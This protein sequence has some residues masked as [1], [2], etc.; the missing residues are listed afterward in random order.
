M[1]TLGA[2]SLAATCASSGSLFV[3]PIFLVVKKTLHA[4]NSSPYM[5]S[6]G[7]YVLLRITRMAPILTT[8]K[9][10]AAYCSQLPA[11]MATRSPCRIPSA[12]R[13]RAIRLD[14]RR[15]SSYDQRA[16]VHGM[17][18]QSAS[19]LCWHCSSR[20][21]PRVKSLRGGST[22]PC[23]IDGVSRWIMGCSTAEGKVCVAIAG[24][25]VKASSSLRSISVRF[26]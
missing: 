3:L 12:S 25:G 26:R 9:K 17:L 8:A 10:T 11:M 13:A 1:T 4:V 18:M 6:E 14:C 20:S 2:L 24:N 7:V 22:G 15:R 16:P 21:S 5:A 23:R 19:P